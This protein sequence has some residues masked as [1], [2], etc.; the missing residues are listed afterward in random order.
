MWHDER[1]RNAVTARNQGRCSVKNGMNVATGQLART[2][3]G[4]TCLNGKY[5]Q[6]TGPH[7]ET[8][9][10]KRSI[11]N[12]FEYVNSGYGNLVREV[13]HNQHGVQ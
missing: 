6:V 5:L 2:L 3:P 8:R 12:D 13:L 11:T 4:F 7:I 1:P 10:E 9:R